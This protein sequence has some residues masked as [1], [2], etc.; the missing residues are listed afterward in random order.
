VR[1]QP[2]LGGSLNFKKPPCPVLKISLNEITSGSGSLRVIRNQITT[3]SSYFKNLKEPTGF[4]KE[5]AMNS[6]SY[7]HF[8]DFL[9]TFQSHGLYIKIDSLNVLRISRKVGIY[10][11]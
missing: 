11:G 6:G 3:G 8:Y 9:Y 1:Y 2:V 7:R 4:M 5:P 10:L